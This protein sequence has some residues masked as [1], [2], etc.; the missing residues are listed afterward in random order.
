MNAVFDAQSFLNQAQSSGFETKFTQVEP[1]EYPAQIKKLGYRTM[2]QK[3]DPSKDSH[4]VD[5]TYVIEDARQ[6]EVTGLAEPSVRQSIFLDL[7]DGK[8]DKSK[9][10]NIGLGRV[11]EALG[12]N[13]G[14]DWAFNDLMGRPCMVK[15]EQSPNLKSPTDP[16]VNVTKVGKLG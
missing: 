16:F 14:R 4:I 13:D 15:V 8:L 10:K 5:I 6:K 12:L 9:N 7:I 2:P 3:D 1:G 11:L